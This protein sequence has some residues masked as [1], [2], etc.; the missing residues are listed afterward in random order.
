MFNVVFR[1]QVRVWK[2]LQNIPKSILSILRTQ[3][4]NTLNTLNIEPSN[5]ANNKYYP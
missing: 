2:K 4:N 1:W 5:S 3:Y